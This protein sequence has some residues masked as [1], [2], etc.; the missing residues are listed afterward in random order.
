MDIVRENINKIG[1]EVFVES[2]VGLG[3][4]FVIKINESKG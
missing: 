1:G 3:T 4:V 2:R